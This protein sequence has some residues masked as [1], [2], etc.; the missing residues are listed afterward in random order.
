[1]PIE[2]VDI[3]GLQLPLHAQ[4]QVKALVIDGRDPVRAALFRWN[5]EYP[6]DYKAIIKVLK[7][8]AQQY[9]VKQEKHVKQSKDKS[10][11]E[12]FEAIAYTRI[13]RL[14]FFYDESEASLIVCTNEYEKSRGDQ[15]AAFARCAAFR[16]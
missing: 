15:D 12:V 4:W 14:M 3:P 11:G 10:H 1:M 16:D 7:L 2:L 5:R 8:A 9:R 6:K 13:T